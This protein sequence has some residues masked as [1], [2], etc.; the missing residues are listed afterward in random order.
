MLRTLLPSSIALEFVHRACPGEV[1]ANAGQ[2]EQLVVNLVLN[3]R[4]AITGAGQITLTLDTVLRDGARWAVLSVQDTGTGM[5]PEISSRIF[6]PFFTTK[7][8]GQGTGLGLAV[9]AGV[10][11][12]HGGTIDVSS[13]PG[14]GSLFTVSLPV[15]TRSGARPQ[16]LPKAAGARGGTEHVLVADDDMRVRVLLERVLT[17][18][19]Y[20]VTLAEDGA[21]ALERFEQS[22]DVALVITDLVMPRLGGDELLRRL[23]GRVKVLLMSGYASHPVVVDASAHVLAKP[24]ATKE[25]LARVREVLDAAPEARAAA[26]GRR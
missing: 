8:Q 5:S 26:G 3:A 21:D 16:A 1:L 19:G 20:R 14:E 25:L 7:R 6:E 13:R 15:L 23:A 17:G 2:I 18:A 11:K 9:V 24:F 22:Q 10:V 4:D 12:S